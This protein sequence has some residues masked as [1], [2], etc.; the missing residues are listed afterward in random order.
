MRIKESFVYLGSLVLGLRTMTFR[1]FWATLHRGTHSDQTNRTRRGKG[2]ARSIV[3]IVHTTVPPVMIVLVL[4][5]PHQIV[6]VHKSPRAGT[7]RRVVLVRSLC[8][9]RRS[10]VDGIDG[11]A[12]AGVVHGQGRRVVGQHAAQG[13]FSD[14]VRYAGIL[15]CGQTGRIRSRYGRRG[16]VGTRKAGSVLLGL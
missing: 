9:P 11:T 10:V 4:V 7:A 14:G 6:V 8:S 16:R 3:H 2:I 5:R 12:D 15:T 1:T 13:V